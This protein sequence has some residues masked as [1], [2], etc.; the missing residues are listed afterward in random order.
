MKRWHIVKI[1]S[2]DSRNERRR[3]IDGGHDR[4]KVES[5]VSHVL[6]G[7]RVLLPQVLDLRPEHIST[8][9][10]SLEEGTRFAQRYAQGTLHL[11]SE[12]HDA[13]AYTWGIETLTRA[14]YEH[15]E[16]SH[17]AQPGFR[18]RHNWGYW[19]GAT[20]IGVGLSAHSL[21]D[22]QRR[23]NTPEVWPYLTAIEAGRSACVGSE[24]L[25]QVTARR[26]RIWLQ[27]RT[28]AGVRL[29]PSERRMLQ[30]TPK[31]QAMLDDGLLHLQGRQL[32]LTPQGFPLA[33]SIGITVV[34]LLENPAL[35]I[36]ASQFD[37]R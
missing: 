4:Q 23:W 18:C 37:P 36:D 21:V 35:P 31:F 11:V 20:Y 10:L 1:H 27:L 5:F 7:K 24:T 15:Y 3:E 14:A 8:Y 26:E 2:E 29:S 25:D 33:D 32:C 9:A 30:R 22:G 28:C 16:V 34:E 13:W 6:R 12:A 17:F 19:H